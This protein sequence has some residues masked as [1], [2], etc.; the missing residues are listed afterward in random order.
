MD[1]LIKVLH[2]LSFTNNIFTAKQDPSLLS[3]PV[4]AAIF[5]IYHAVIVSMTPKGVLDCFMEERAELLSKYRFATEQALARANF[6]STRNIMTLQAFALFL[7][8][9]TFDSK[10]IVADSWQLTAPHENDHGLAR[11][12]TGNL[13][14][15]AQSI[16]LHRDVPESGISPFEIEIR[17]RLWWNICALDCSTSENHGIEP[18]ITEISVELPLNLNDADLH[19]S[20]AKTPPPS[21]GATDI[22][23][24]LV[25]FQ[26]ACM[27][28][29]FR[30]AS[31]KRA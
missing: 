28:A 27:N 10:S 14:R 13:I 2:V 11:N 8:S 15:S 1:P 29:Q 7:V 9:I 3:K 26:M 25:K 12:L 20:M 19:P 31:G 5:A 24:C 22:T 4:E 17:R 30:S 23:L 6:L 18:M 21:T 16:G